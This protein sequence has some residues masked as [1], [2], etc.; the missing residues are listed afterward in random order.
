MEEKNDLKAPKTYSL[1]PAVI[2]WVTQRAALLTIESKGRVSE[3]QVVNDILR[4][5]MEADVEENENSPT[6]NKRKTN[7]KIRPA[8]AEAVAA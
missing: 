5:A 7:P 6:S 4:A 3:S 1:E 8:R 2:A